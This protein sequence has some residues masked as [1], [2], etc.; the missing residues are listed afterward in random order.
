MVA[1]RFNDYFSHPLGYRVTTALVANN[2]HTDQ[3]R[4]STK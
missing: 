3:K 4:T 2:S 1:L